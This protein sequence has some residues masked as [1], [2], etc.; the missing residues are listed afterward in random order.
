VKQHIEM[1]EATPLTTDQ[2]QR[3]A[4]LMSQSRMLRAIANVQEICNKTC[5]GPQITAFMEQKAS[6]DQSIAE[7]INA[8]TGMTSAHE[9][10]AE[11][12]ATGGMTQARVKSL[13]GHNPFSVKRKGRCYVHSITRMAKDGT[14][15]HSVY[16][17]SAYA[18][19]WGVGA[20]IEHRMAYYTTV[21]DKKEGWEERR[22]KMALHGEFAYPSPD[23]KWHSMPIIKEAWFTMFE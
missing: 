4:L 17:G 18:D 5:R 3:K 2:Q 13:G 16:A 7:W 23:S 8:C 6:S 1:L 21:I 11:M 14:T 20:G 19:L 15:Y 12:I 9:I 22:D 10:L